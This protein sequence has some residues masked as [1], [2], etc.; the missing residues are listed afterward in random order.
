MKTNRQTLSL[1]CLLLSM[2]PINDISSLQNKEPFPLNMSEDSVD[3]MYSTCEEEM[4]KTVKETYFKKEMSNGLF[5]RAWNS[6]TKCTKR[7][8]QSKDKEDEALTENHL[9]A[10]C[11]YTDGATGLYVKFNKAVR[12]GRK[13]YGSSFQFHFL[14]FWLTR[15]VQILSGNENCHKTYRRTKS[16]FSG[17]VNKEVRFGTFT[18]TSKLT[19]LT[20]FGEKT[21]FKI[22]TC[23]GAFFKK[24]PVLQDKEQE[25]LIPPYEKFN[26]TKKCQDKDCKQLE[27][28]PDCETVYVLESTGVQSNLDC[29]IAKH[30]II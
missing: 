13:D 15:A 24:Y 25:V 4:E 9:R 3:D 19:N 28:L 23:S 18:S 5:K 29:Q 6:A 16:T 26:I 7:N 22:T 1:L 12:T 27:N 2:L 30:I 21:C 8:L 14:H 11:I 10:I 17:E 20:H